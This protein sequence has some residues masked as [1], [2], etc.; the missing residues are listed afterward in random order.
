MDLTFYSKNKEMT[1]KLF[2]TNK[3]DQEL[4]YKTYCWKSTNKNIE[5]SVI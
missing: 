1:E 2:T 3:T 4:T 5:H